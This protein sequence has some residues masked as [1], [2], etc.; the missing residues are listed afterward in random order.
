VFYL[1]NHTQ[2]H[3]HSCNQRVQEQ[4]NVQ[5]VATVYQEYDYISIRP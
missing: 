1:W 4:R 3:T 5:H 2:E